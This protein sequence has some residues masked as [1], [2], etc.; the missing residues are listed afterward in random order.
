MTDVDRQKLEADHAALEGELNAL[1]SLTDQMQVDAEAYGV[2]L[3]EAL[4][5]FDAHVAKVKGLN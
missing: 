2:R 5:Q 4:A 3:T 1:S